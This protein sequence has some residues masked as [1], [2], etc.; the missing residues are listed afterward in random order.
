LP[1]RLTLRLML[2]AARYRWKLNKP[3]I[4]E[5]LSRLPRGGTAIDCGGHKGA[6]SFWMAKRVG[7]QGAV[8]TIEPQPRMVEIIKA[9]FPSGWKSRMNIVQAAASDHVGESVLKMRPSSTHGATLDD[10]EK[11]A[12]FV[13]V[14]VRLVTLDQLVRENTCKRVDFI[15]ID[16]EGHEIA[17]VRGAMESVARFKPA[18]LIESEA[19]SHDGSDQHLQTLDSLLKP[20]GY[21]GRFHDGTRWRPLSEL[22]VNVHQQY[23]AGR[24]CN[25]ILFVCE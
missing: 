17:V 10:F 14:P 13:S 20:H 2:R 18:M 16:A 8:I 3:E 7:P 12:E 1:L 11:G 25:N 19:R 22:D 9:S 24:Y 23:G 6:Y 21:Q 5:M 4:A 15:K